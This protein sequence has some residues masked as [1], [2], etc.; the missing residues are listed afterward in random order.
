VTHMNTTTDPRNKR[1]DGWGGW[2]SLGERCL[3]IETVEAE[4]AE[5]LRA[6]RRLDAWR[7]RKAVA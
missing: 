3:R 6:D 5:S 2:D 1:R 7:R 4:M